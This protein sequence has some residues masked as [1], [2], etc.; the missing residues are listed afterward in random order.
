MVW[1]PDGDML[2]LEKFGGLRVLRQGKLDP[3]VITD[4]VPDDAYKAGSNGLL[5]IALDPDYSKNHRVFI[6]YDKGTATQSHASLYRARFTGDALVDG[7]I[8]FQAK[9]ENYVA[10]NSSI[11]RIVFLPDKTMLI[12]SGVDDSRRHLA[13][14]LDN[15]LG[16]ILRLDRDGHAPRDNPFFGK[17]GVLPQIFA[18]GVRNPIGLYRDPTTGIIWE[19]ENEMRGGDELN[20]VRPGVNLGWPITTYGKEYTGGEITKLREAPGIQGPI[21]YWAPSIAPSGL[22]VVT[23]DR[24]PLWRGNVFLGALAGQHLRRVVIQEGKA[25]EQEMLLKELDERIRD[26][27]QGPDG[28]LYVLTDNTNG[29]LL[30]LQPGTPSEPQMAL[31][32]KRLPHSNPTI[33]TL[34]M[35]PKPVDVARGQQLATQLCSQCHTFEPGGASKIGPNLAGIFGRTAGTGNHPYSPAMRGAAVT[36][37]QDTLDRYLAGPRAFIL[38]TTMTAAPIPVTQD[39]ADIIAYLKSCCSA[40]PP[41]GT[42]HH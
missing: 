36:W 23:S 7:K 6:T 18:Y 37:K 19:N 1:L 32:A 31:V 2:I 30:R 39:R 22:T 20:I 8:I 16:K 3:K 4:G 41:P 10:P 26:V 14:K 13:Q 11:S 29:R 9:P 40:A 38:D 25:V 12:G 42:T 33:E 15:D 34:D 35:R 27:R 24:Y 28:Y 21:T 17:P 5:E